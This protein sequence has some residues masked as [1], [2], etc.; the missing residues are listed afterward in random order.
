ME[1][2]KFLGKVIG[3]YLIIIAVA[4]FVNMHQFVI[5]VQA[6]INN[7]ALMFVSGFFTLILGILVVVSHNIWKWHW[8]VIVTII[9]WITLVK[10]ASLIFYPHFIDK[11][12]VLFIQNPQVA[13][14]SAGL[15]FVIGLIL[16]YFSFKR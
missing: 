10:G 7:A 3:I 2:S 6:L 11:V 12:T 14:F 8:R 5:Y 9:G 4:L 15:D 13:Y 1:T 16:V